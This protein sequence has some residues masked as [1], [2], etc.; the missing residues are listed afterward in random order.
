MSGIRLVF[1]DMEG[2][3]FEPSVLESETRVP[4][5]AWFTI[6]QRLGAGAL[7]EERTTQARWKNGEY[8]GYVDWM[9]DT[10]RIHA[11][12]GLTREV[13]AGILDSIAYM[14]GAKDVFSALHAGGVRTA[15]VTGGFKYQADRAARELGIKH[16]FAGC[17][18][19]WS[20]QGKLV[21][22]NL[23][24]ADYD[25]KVDFMRLLA[26]DYHFDE[27]ELAFVGDGDNDVAL[28]RQVGTSIAFHGSPKLSESCTYAV[29]RGQGKKDLSEVLP[30]L[31][32]S[33][34]H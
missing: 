7:E 23:L 13:F 28:A 24:P 20:D 30:Y 18:Y 16:V 8:S 25:G 10:I 22:W 15:L 3:V 6:A 29:G 34:D 32:F 12:Y 1:F 19:Y 31:G 2:T 9:E 17:E 5:S 11:K 14:D 21:H 4:R 27:S 33:R 26:S